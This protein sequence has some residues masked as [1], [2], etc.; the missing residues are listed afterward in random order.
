MSAA[1]AQQTTES[2]AF[3]VGPEPQP[4]GAGE[5]ALEDAERSDAVQLRGLRGFVDALWAARLGQPGA[6]NA[7]RSEIQKENFLDLSDGSCL[8]SEPSHLVVEKGEEV[9][10]VR[11]TTGNAVS[12]SNARRSLTRGGLFLN[13][14][15]A[16]FTAERDGRDAEQAPAGS[17]MRLGRRYVAARL[18][19][20]AALS[21]S[22]ALTVTLC[23]TLGDDGA[24][25][26]VVVTSVL[27]RVPGELSAE[28]EA[29]AAIAADDD[30]IAELAASILSDGGGDGERA[31]AAGVWRIAHEDVNVYGAVPSVPVQQLP[32]LPPAPRSEAEAAD[33]IRSGSAPA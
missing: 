18:L 5:R 31:E 27:V 17:N 12:T 7:G 33:W 19:H 25:R 26:R 32:P 13:S 6:S 3:E 8:I 23:R 9:T 10:R 2:S 21:P 24:R 30:E 4:L 14:R 20:A 29:I 11:I 28:E 22:A 15:P 1:A 16:I